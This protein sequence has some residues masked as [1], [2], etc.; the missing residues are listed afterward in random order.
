MNPTN[1]ESKIEQPQKSKIISSPQLSN[2]MPA[3]KESDIGWLEH[4]DIDVMHFSFLSGVGSHFGLKTLD[5][6]II[7]CIWIFSKRKGFCYLSKER[8]AVLVCTNPVSLYQHLG[9]LKKKQYIEQSEK[10]MGRVTLLR[11]SPEV[12]DYVNRTKSEIDKRRE[13]NKKSSKNNGY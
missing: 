12:Q 1:I 9:S 5:V 3:I 11:L 4:M 6:A 13:R 10:T 8:M 2:Q 7:C